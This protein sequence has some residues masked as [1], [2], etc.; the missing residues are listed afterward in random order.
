MSKPVILRSGATKNLSFSAL[1][2]REILR[3]VAA[4]PKTDEENGGQLRSE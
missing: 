1:F 3:Y 4:R 2:R